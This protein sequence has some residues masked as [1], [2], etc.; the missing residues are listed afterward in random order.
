MHRKRPIQR[1]DDPNR[2]IRLNVADMVKRRMTFVYFNEETI[3]F[4]RHKLKI[5]KR[6][7]RGVVV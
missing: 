4:M 2:R 6:I 1:Q 7:L 5:R 3:L